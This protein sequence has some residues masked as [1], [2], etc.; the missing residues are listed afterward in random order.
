MIYLNPI[1]KIVISCLFI[2]L[3]MTGCSAVSPE[4]QPIEATVS[5]Y[6]QMRTLITKSVKDAEAKGQKKVFIH[7]KEDPEVIQPADLVTL[8]YT[9]TDPQGRLVYS[10]RP[11]M[12]A[13]LEGAYADLFGQGMEATGP[14]MV[15]GGISSLFP[16][17]GHAVLG[18]RSGDQVKVDVSPEKTFG[19]YDDS[20]INKFP[21]KRK[22][23]KAFRMPVDAYFNKFGHAPESGRQVDLVPYFKSKVTSVRDS[24]VMLESMVEEGRTIND[25]FGTATLTIEEDHILISLNPVVGAVFPME[26]K[27]GVIS[28][29]DDAYFYVDFNHVLAGKPL[30][31]NVAVL[32][33][34]KFSK[35]E[36]MEI[37]WNDDF[38][39]AMDLASQQHKPVVLVLYAQWCGWSKKLLHTTFNDPRIKQ[40]GDRLVWLKLDSDKEQG[41]K[42]MFDQTGFPMVVI[43]DQ[44]G[45]VLQT[46][47][48]F[49][50][51]G[52]LAMALGSVVAGSGAQP[53]VN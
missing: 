5:D 29:K 17:T 15:L 52:T 23:S 35:F 31:F 36:K 25:D 41:Y 47:N 6:S 40:Y 37:P 42:E 11:E 44:E 7:L 8:D 18:L 45:E 48:G 49:Q 12:F 20:K 14:E 46:M 53:S 1:I 32:D 10:T 43:M 33:L 51:G 2:V 3:T 9:V 50:D 38:N 24:V 27:K 26:D 34:Q 30:T 19:M 22:V 21:R 4:P 13:R 16:G 39:A 28:D